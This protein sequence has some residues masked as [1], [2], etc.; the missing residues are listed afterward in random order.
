MYIAF[1]FRGAPSLTISAHKLFVESFPCRV[2]MFMQRSVGA[3]KVRGFLCLSNP[4]SYF[5]NTLKERATI[6]VHIDFLCLHEEIPFAGF[7]LSFWLRVF[8]SLNLLL[9]CDTPLFFLRSLI[10]PLKLLC[11]YVCPAGLAH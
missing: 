4:P 10:S 11:S 7:W 5:K 1:I 9:S 8:W 2:F 3:S 6:S